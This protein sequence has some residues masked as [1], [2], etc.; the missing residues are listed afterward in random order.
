MNEPLDAMQR[1]AEIDRLRDEIRTMEE[2]VGTRASQVDKRGGTEEDMR[3]IGELDRHAADLRPGL[4][5]KVKE[6]RQLAPQ[7]FQAWVG[8]NQETLRRRIM[9]ELQKERPDVKTI[10]EGLAR[11]RTDATFSN[12]D[13]LVLNLVGHLDAWRE[14]LEGKAP[15]ALNPPSWETYATL[16]PFTLDLRTAHPLPETLAGR[17]PDIVKVA[18]WKAWHASLVFL[19]ETLSILD[20]GKPCR[21][22]RSTGSRTPGQPWESSWTLSTGQLALAL[23]WGEKAA[24]EGDALAPFSQVDVRGLLPAEK[25]DWSGSFG[26]ET[27]GLVIGFTGLREDRGEAV[28]ALA[29]RLFAEVRDGPAPAPSPDIPAPPT[30]P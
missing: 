8:R 3:R 5:R 17:H 2:E 18:E 22:E 24:G 14:L 30:A 20:F 10:D 29:A 6:I 23:T 28:R 19:A 12:A 9:A 25:I 7:A 21:L 11:I 16:P 15:Y 1:L 4:T 26:G 13:L 27:K